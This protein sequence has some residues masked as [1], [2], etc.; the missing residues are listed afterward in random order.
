MTDF[1]HFEFRMA[2]AVSQEETKE[3]ASALISYT[4]AIN[5]RPNDVSCL[6]RRAE[7]YLRMADLPSAILGYRKT[8]LLVPD[9]A[10][11]CRRLAF[12]YYLHGQC[13]FE[14]KLYRCALESF[15]KARNVDQCN[16]WFQY[17]R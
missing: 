14:Q 10:A 13:L 5:L 7:C 4:K 17:R 12:L 1:L 2:I 9:D 6:V 3:Y 11:C 8:C 16:P 15:E